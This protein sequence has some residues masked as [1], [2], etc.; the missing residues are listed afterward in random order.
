MSAEKALAVMRDGTERVLDAR[1]Y[2]AFWS[3]E[4]TPIPGPY[5]SI[6]ALY[7]SIDL[8]AALRKYWMAQGSAARDLAEALKWSD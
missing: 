5:S 7:V 4:V 3:R 1:P 6:V 2:D 8:E